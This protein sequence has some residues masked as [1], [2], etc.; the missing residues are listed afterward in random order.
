MRHYGGWS[1][2]A[3]LEPERV[4]V[5]ELIVQRD[6]PRARLDPHGRQVDGSCP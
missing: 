2:N 6:L 4:E 1:R 5:R 3:R